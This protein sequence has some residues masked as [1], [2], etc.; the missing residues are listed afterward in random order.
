MRNSLHI[1]WEEEFTQVPV[2]RVGAMF[3]VCTGE[4]FVYMCTGRPWFGLD[5]RVS[6]RSQTR[7]VAKNTVST[8]RA[9]QDC[10]VLRR[11]SR[12][13]RDREVR[14]GISPAKS[15]S[16]FMGLLD[17]LMFRAQ[18]TEAVDRSRNFQQ[19]WRRRP[20]LSID[21]HTLLEGDP[22]AHFVVL[23]NYQEDESMHQETLENLGSSPPTE[24]HKCIVLTMK[25]RVRTL[26][27]KPSVSWQRLATNSR[28]RWPP[29]IQ[30]VL[31]ER[32]LASSSNVQWAI[33][34]L[35]RKCGVGLHPSNLSSGFMTVGDADTLWRPHFFSAVT[36]ESQRSPELRPTAR[37]FSNCGEPREPVLRY[38]SRLLL[39]HYAAYP[40]ISSLGV[41]AGIPT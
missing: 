24:K 23:P 5:R 34:Q 22:V 9:Q 18:L 36:F 25:G 29:I 37:L 8:A 38:S 17:F 4:V 15:M 21:S 7:F 1:G 31:L 35:W 10:R 30:L 13:N 16:P 20:A 40:G 19:H 6:L 39:L 2:A 11:V 27:T 12:P 26:E 3:V 14:T 28:T 32:R 33:R 41:G